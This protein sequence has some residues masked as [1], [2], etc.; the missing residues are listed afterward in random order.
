M[1]LCNDAKYSL[2]LRERVRVRGR[3]GIFIVGLKA[4]PTFNGGALAKTRLMPT[5][6]KKRN[7]HDKKLISITKA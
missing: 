5:T 4:Q 1:R 6:K 3:A 7:E 2:A